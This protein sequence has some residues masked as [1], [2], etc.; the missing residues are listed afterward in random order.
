MPAM[1]KQADAVADAELVD[2]LAEPHQ[3]DRAGGHGQHG[4]DLPAER[5]CRPSA[6]RNAA[7]HEA[8]RLDE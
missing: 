3:E 4:D 2:L 1:I 8:L 6:F 5:A 7:D